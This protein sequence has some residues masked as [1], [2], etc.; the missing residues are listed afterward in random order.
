M[1]WD[2]LWQNPEVARLWQEMPPLPQ[3]VEMADRLA[4]E[5]RS[6]VLDVGCGLG[7]HAVYL[8]ARGFQVT[9][10]DNSPT[11][12]AACEENLRKAGL[13]ATVMQLEMTEFPFPDSSFDG[14]I[15]SHVI[16]HCRRAT[17]ERIIASIARKLAPRGYFA[18][19][20]PSARHCHCGSGA[21]IEP[22]TWVDP[23]HPEGPIPHHYC[24]EAEVR[25]LL[26]GY[27]IVSLVEH[28]YQGDGKSHCHWRVLARKTT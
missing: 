15:G 5:G 22:G 3:V 20:T 21:E 2:R 1:G 13:S 4:A 10:T 24:T 26:E 8:A 16:H 11:A 23:H 18:W 17:L 9:A 7:R 19:A 27:E 6:R 12:I 14:V 25:E 28:E